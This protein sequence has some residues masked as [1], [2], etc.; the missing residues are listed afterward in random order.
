MITVEFIKETIIKSFS[1]TNQIFYDRLCNVMN[2]NAMFK[3]SR[4]ER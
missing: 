1:S 4:N 3:E 2:I